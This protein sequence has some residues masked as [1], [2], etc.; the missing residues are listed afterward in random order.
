MCMVEDMMELVEEELDGLLLLL[1]ESSSYSD[2][3]IFY[4]DGMWGYQ[5]EGEM[6]QFDSFEDMVYTIEALVKE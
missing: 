2:P 3:Q 5:R 6:E 1:E 4:A